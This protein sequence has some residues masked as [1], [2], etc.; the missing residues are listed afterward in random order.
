MYRTAIAHLFQGNDYLNM[1]KHRELYR[2]LSNA[3][4]KV[5]DTAN[6]LE[7]IIVKNN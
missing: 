4:D 2:H 6:V 1:F 7:D 3:A 5:H